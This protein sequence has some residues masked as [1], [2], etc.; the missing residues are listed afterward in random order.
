VVRGFLAL[1]PRSLK[2]DL[3]AALR[4][5]LRQL[6]EEPTSVW[7]ADHRELQ[8]L[9]TREEA[10][11]AQLRRLADRIAAL[12]ATLGQVGARA[13]EHD[14]TLGQLQ[15]IQRREGTAPPPPPRHLQIRV[16][17]AYVH[18]FLESGFAM[19]DDLDA[20]LAPIGRALPDFSRILDWG[21]G[22]GRTTRALKARA[23]ESALSGTDIDPEA[24]GWLAQN[25]GRF[26]E[27]RVA[28]HHPPTSYADAAF[29]LIV[30]I[31]VFTHLP[32]DMQFEWLGELQR[33][34]RPGG[35]LVMTTSG[36]QNYRHL[37][38]EL[39]EVLASKGFLYCDSKYGQ[40]VSLP[41]F[42]QNTFHSH[43]YIRRAWSPYFEIV[44]IQAGRLR[45]HQD[46]I[47][48]RNRE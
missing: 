21:C 36:E 29:D 18:D 33:I 8:A 2:N 42:Y 35:Y 44:E 31:S 41:G 30:G 25:Y 39:Q 48:L 26:A 40:S 9:R 7:A 4:G 16:V 28:P 15:T 20:V 11:P 47:L 3:K 37:P 43:E 10:R 17:G 22:C 34:T 23:P 27:F 46:T 5:L 38:S 32:E 6:L 1:I 14:A 12:E 19:C 24:I 45:Q 13:A